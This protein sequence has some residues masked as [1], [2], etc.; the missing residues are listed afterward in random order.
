MSLPRR[1]LGQTGIEVSR[2]CYGSLT[3]GPAQANLSPERGGELLV[4]ALSRGVNFIDTAE[5]YETYPHIRAGLRTVATM[6]VIASKCYAYDRETARRSFDQARLAMDLDVIDL[7]LLHEQE[8]T[9]TLDGHREAFAYFHE[10]KEKGLI[11]AIGISTHA[12]EPVRALTQARL[13]L[14]G[15]LWRDLDMGLYREADVIHPLLNW[16]GLGL[17]DGTAEAMVLATREAEAAGLGLY[18]MKM[19]G[20]GHFLHEFDTALSFALAQDQVAAYAVGMQSE[21]EIDMNI[22]LFSGLAVDPGDLAATRSRS[23][24]LVVSDWCTGCGACVGR[25]AAK[26]LS[27]SETDGKVKVDPERCVLCGYCA[28]ACR[29]FVLKVV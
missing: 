22:A 2:L 27:L 4:H 11:R 3:L 13:G 5:L 10:Q 20:G 23:R 12:V 7:F 14:A 19:L 29:D 6:P 16:R 8:S 18:G 15:T 9:L 26:A 21:A 24:R 17:I 25:C 28:Y 1:F